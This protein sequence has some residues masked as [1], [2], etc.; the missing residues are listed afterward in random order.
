[1]GVNTLVVTE[2][3]MIFTQILIVMSGG[4]WKD[5]SDSEAY[6]NRV[7]RSLKDR[8]VEIYSVGVGASTSALQ[9][10][11]ISSGRRYWFLSNS[12][13]DLQYVRPR[14]LRSIRGGKLT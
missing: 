5:D 8:G 10:R 11:D 4:S 14:L 7:L 12:Y 3:A 9:M 2:T 1:M 13:D 6:R